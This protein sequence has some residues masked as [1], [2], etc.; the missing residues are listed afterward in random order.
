MTKFLSNLLPQI[1]LVIAGIG[2]V[3]L[4]TALMML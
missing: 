3:A 1:I 4:H 2:V